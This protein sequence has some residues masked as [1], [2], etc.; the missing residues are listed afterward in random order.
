[1][2]KKKFN[3]RAFVSL[4]MT[5]AFII[6]IIS[7]I[8]LFIAPP[9]RIAHWSYWA[10]LGFTKSE[11]QAFHIMFT[12]IFVIAGVLH[13]IYNWKP[14]VKYFSNKMSG[15]TSLRKELIYSIVFSAFIFGGTYY[16]IPPFVNVIDLGEYLTDSWSEESTEPPIPHAEE[17]TI[18]EI[19]TQTNITS[20]QIIET[21]NKNGFEVSDSNLTLQDIAEKYDI[22]PSDIYKLITASTNQIKNSDV[23][24]NYKQGSGY[25]RKMLS[26]IFKEN[27][28][29]WEEGIE[30]LKKHGILVSEDGK[31][32][33]IAT[34]N[35]KLPIDIINLIK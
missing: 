2:K 17:L 16:K 23:N 8:V 9:G 30:L 25:G 18:T 20:N 26:D 35:G 24:N 21:L 4:Y 7:G 32:K 13:I 15:T 29:T 27:N 22:V 5:I 19:S 3:L 11:W 12:F 33:D 28:L 31:V 34:E 14:L 10:M 1:M 6:M